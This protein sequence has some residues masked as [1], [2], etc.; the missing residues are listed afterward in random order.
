MS[1]PE[2]R[3]SDPRNVFGS[4]RRCCD[5]ERPVPAWSLA[6]FN[7]SHGQEIRRYLIAAGKRNGLPEHL[8][9]AVADELWCR[10]CSTVLEDVRDG[11]AEGGPVFLRLVA[12]VAAFIPG[13]G[14]G[15]ATALGAAASLAEGNSIDDAM[16]DAAMS[17]IPAG[18]AFQ[19]AGA[20]GKSLLEGEPLDQALLEGGRALAESQGG[21]L[22]AAAYDAAIVVAQGKALQDAG[23]AGLKALAKGNDVAER[24]ASYAETI[25]RAAQGGMSVEDMLTSELAATLARE[26]GATVSK[27]LDGAVERVRGNLELL[28]AGSQALAVALQVPESVARAAQAVLRAGDGS[29]D[30]DMLRSLKPPLKLGRVDT[31]NVV[32]DRTICEAA[33]DAWS[34]GSPAAPTLRRMCD[35]WRASQPTLAL[36]RVQSTT[37]D[38]RTICEAAADAARRG[39]PAASGLAR[40]CEAWRAAGG[41]EAPSLAEEL[42]QAPPVVAPREG[43][44]SSA[45]ADV[46]L[47]GVVAAAAVAL[48]LWARD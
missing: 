18:A 46:A 37:E 36:G 16:V 24:A 20:V 48:F 28:N 3:Y 5:G 21:V 1:T 40:Q 32:D 47:G 43:S 13:I 39:S 30:L 4:G 41:D 6:A 29:A 44:R 35:E 45:T 23:F 2:R 26:A 42:T 17:A 34:R 31:S 14:T 8:A 22:A 19:T 33:A 9:I 7:Y 38:T 10:R 11:F 12:T 27:Q 15:V 25:V